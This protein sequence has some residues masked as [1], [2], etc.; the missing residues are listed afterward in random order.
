MEDEAALRTLFNPFLTNLPFRLPP[1]RKAN[2]NLRDSASL[3]R[4]APTETKVS[5]D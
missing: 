1:R 4:L 2:I 3:L 5:S